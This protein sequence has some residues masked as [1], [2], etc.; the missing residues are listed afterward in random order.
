MG[1]S[2]VALTKCEE[3]KASCRLPYVGRSRK[4][5]MSPGLLGGLDRSG[6]GEVRTCGHGHAYCRVGPCRWTAS[7][8]VMNLC[9][10]GCNQRNNL[11]VIVLVCMCALVMHICTHASVACGYMGDLDLPK[12]NVCRAS[13]SRS[14][15]GEGAGCTVGCC[16]RSKLLS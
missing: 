1:V 14:W 2:R 11:L 9:K 15:M 5:E 6:M 4:K 3:V 12:M 10:V 16:N 8:A 7:H 13:W